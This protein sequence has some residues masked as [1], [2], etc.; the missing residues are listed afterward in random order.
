MSG[1]GGAGDG[2]GVVTGIWLTEAAAAPMRRVRSARLLAGRGLE[3]D[4]YALGGGTWAQYPDL[5]KQLTLIDAADVAAVAA[6]VGTELTPGDTRRNLVTAGIDL[7]SLVGRWFAVGD[8]LLFGM[9]RCPPCTH[10]ERL[11]GARLVKAMVHR[12]GI[13]AAVFAGAAIAEG[14][15]VR[16][17]PEEEPVRRGAPTGPDRPVPRVVGG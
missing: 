2:P 9:K 7:P 8:A 3:G 14:A 16:T 4:R 11:T 15:P 6:E 13:N 5:E 10:L 1:P 12:G 17:V